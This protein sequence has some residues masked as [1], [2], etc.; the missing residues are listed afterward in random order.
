MQKQ[1]GFSGFDEAK[2]RSAGDAGRHQRPRHQEGSRFE[3]RRFSTALFRRL[4]RK[5]G[6]QV[7]VQGPENNRDARINMEVDVLLA[8]HFQRLMQH[9]RDFNFFEPGNNF[10]DEAGIVSFFRLGLAAFLDFCV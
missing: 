2:N 3:Q 4:D 7:R 8:D 1:R 6:R 5:P 9:G 10:R